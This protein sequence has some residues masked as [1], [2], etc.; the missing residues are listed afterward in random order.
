MELP[1]Q[2]RSVLRRARTARILIVFFATVVGPSLMAISRLFSEDAELWRWG[3][4]ASGFSLSIIGGF[5]TLFTSTDGADLLD[6]WASA[7]ERAR[8]ERDKR[9]A[10]EKSMK[11]SDARHVLLKQLGDIAVLAPP[12]DEGRRISIDA[13][14]DSLVDLR[15]RLFE[16]TPKEQYNFCVYEY[17]V[18]K[19][20]LEC[21]SVRRAWGRA[22]HSPRSWEPGRGHVGA[23]FQ[24][25]ARIVYP[26]CNLPDIAR[27]LAEAGDM[28]EADRKR[29]VSVAAA[30]CFGATGDIVG[31]VVA[32]SNKVGRFSYDNGD[33]LDALEDWARWTGF[34]LS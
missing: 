19:N 20:K 30:P 2:L 21:V 8:S 9:L 6:D 33:M 25:Q 12:T 5:I 11:R 27:Q 17:D 1:G 3:L 16:M 10:A 32:T 22:D 15:S 24:R 31:V 7:Q 4:A 23:A 34:I 14:L 29:Y 28:S 18:A 26:D 13:H